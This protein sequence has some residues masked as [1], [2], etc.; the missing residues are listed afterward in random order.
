MGLPRD[1]AAA[2]G[3]GRQAA[4]LVGAMEVGA[5]EVG[6]AC[7][8]ARFLAV[9]LTEMVGVPNRSDKESRSAATARS[10]PS[11][12]RRDSRA[13]TLLRPIAMSQARL[14]CPRYA[15]RLQIHRELATLKPLGPGHPGRLF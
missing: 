3:R 12:Q 11:P 7:G 6:A 14:P 4:G 2:G 13:V 10:A 1:L 5:V 8:I 15:R 9:H